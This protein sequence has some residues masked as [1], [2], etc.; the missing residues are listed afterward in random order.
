MLKNEEAV[1]QN[2]KIDLKKSEEDNHDVY[3]LLIIVVVEHL[4]VDLN[5][6]IN[7]F[8][9]EIMMKIVF[10]IID[11]VHQDLDFIND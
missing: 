8:V 10:Q 11:F 4:I 1:E 6:V 9:V 3:N 5:F 2:E 7:V